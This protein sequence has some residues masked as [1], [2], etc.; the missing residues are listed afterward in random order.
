MTI[1][2][3]A[4]GLR[5]GVCTSTSRPS[6]PFDGQVIYE[7]DTNTLAV[8]DGSGWVSL[9]PVDRDRN[10]IINGGMVVDQRNTATTAITTN[11]YTVDQFFVEDGSTAV[12]SSQQTTDVPTGQ[13]FSN[14]LRCTATT[15]DTSVG[16]TEFSVIT[17]FVEGTNSRKL[18]FGS[19]S[20]KTITVSF[21]VKATV[22]GTYSLTIYNNGASRIYPASYV[23]NS[24]N[25]WEKKTITIPGDTTGTWLTTN[26]RGLV[27]NWYMLLG[28]NFLGTANAWNGSGIYGVT[29]QAN[30]F[31]STNNTFFLTGVQ[32]EAGAVATPFEFE[33]YETTLSKCQRYFTRF[34]LSDTAPLAT[35]IAYATTATATP[36]ILPTR[37]RAAPTAVTSSNVGLT[38]YT[39]GYAITGLSMSE[40]SETS[41]RLLATGTTGLTQSRPYV[42]RG[43]GN[44]AAHISI[45]A[46]L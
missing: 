24:S 2:A 41:V 11:G 39:A 29:G 18:H 25:T 13:G 10:Y 20:A 37:M 30:A 45:S 46:E 22:S 42:L 28:S 6:A 35:G 27:I 14:S 40:V 1:S 8:Y 3:T 23:I 17:S 7:T 4:Q 9:N 19:S 34:V 15:A 36:V 38:D 32:L 44:A 21:W 16:A 43:D 26:G 31:S 5:P 12:L 33:D